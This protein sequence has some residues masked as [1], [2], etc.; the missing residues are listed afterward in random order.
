MSLPRLGKRVYSLIF[1]VLV[2]LGVYGV[3]YY[4][5]VGVAVRET[6]SDLRLLN[7]D[8]G[9]IS[10]GLYGDK[11]RYVDGLYA[12]ILI[13]DCI[14]P[15]WTI[16]VYHDHTVPTPV[17]EKLKNL[18][19]DLKLVEDIKGNIAG[20][21]WRFLA[22]LD[23]KCPRFLIRDTDS[24]LSERE[25]AAV[26]DWILDDTDFH[27]MRDHPYHHVPIM[28]GMWGGKYGIIKEKDLYKFIHPDA[29]KVDMDTYMGDQ[30]FL[31]EHIWPVAQK[32]GYTAHDSYRCK[33]YPNSK[34][35]PTRRTSLAHFV[36]KAVPGLYPPLTE[37]CPWAC[38]PANHKDW[39]F[40]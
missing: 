12:N 34:P 3:W 26:E 18:K 25:R 8:V 31:K 40:C 30:T 5:N 27:F 28:G 10:F 11:D 16:R 37:P 17:L 33:K 32:R 15:D 9:C 1:F 39:L 24:M 7:E 6:A 29:D 23:P 36:G 35:F 20:M 2:S 19:A 38:R 14:F 13:A 4:Q 21:F 22:A